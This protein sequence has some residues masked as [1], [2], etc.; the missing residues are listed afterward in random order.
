MSKRGR[1]G[2]VSAERL[3][4]NMKCVVQCVCL[5]SLPDQDQVHW[6]EAAAGD[7]GEEGGDY[8]WSLGWLLRTP[9]YSAKAFAT[10]IAP[11]NGERLLA[12]SEVEDPRKTKVT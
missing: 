7:P 8:R 1:Q 9:Q 6:P 12:V 5:G 11:G 10:F 3:R 4:E 2:P